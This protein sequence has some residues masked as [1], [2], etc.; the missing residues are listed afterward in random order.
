MTT[1]LEP[2]SQERARWSSGHSKGPMQRT[3]LRQSSVEIVVGKMPHPTSTLLYPILTFLL[4]TNGCGDRVRPCDF[5]VRVFF[6]SNNLLLFCLSMLVKYLRISH[7]WV[8]FLF[9]SL[10]FYDL[11][12]MRLLIAAAFVATCFA[13]ASA[14]PVASE[15][16]FT[17]FF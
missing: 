1:V 2:L 6:T 7:H 5:L 13:M 11:G 15:V 3:V 12:R 17:T 4:Q 16:H 9:I 14:K 10:L 8:F